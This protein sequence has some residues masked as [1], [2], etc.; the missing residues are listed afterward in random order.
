MSLN[1][2][3]E[4]SEVK[5]NKLNKVDTKY[6]HEKCLIEWVKENNQPFCSI[7]K[8][9]LVYTYVIKKYNKKI[10]KIN[11]NNFTQQL[12]YLIVT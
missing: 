4:Y 1:F 6:A 11:I 9:K 8:Y 10:P 2:L 7:C 5:S 12:S 3:V